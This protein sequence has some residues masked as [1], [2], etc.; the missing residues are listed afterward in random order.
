MAA[1]ASREWVCE[2]RRATPARPGAR[3]GG[4][5][6]E[7]LGK[8]GGVRRR[9]RFSMRGFFLSLFLLVRPRSR[10]AAR[11]PVAN[12]AGMGCVWVA[13]CPRE[14][15]LAGA[16]APNPD[17]ALTLR[18]AGQLLVPHLYSRLRLFSPPF[19]SLPTRPPFSIRLPG[20][21]ASGHARARVRTYV[22]T[23]TRMRE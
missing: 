8:R 18:Y 12:R 1:I 3:R 9:R 10:A 23:Y 2:T 19:V 7:G 11:L 14:A 15:R 4:C 5:A 17:V 16:V 22:H 21:R 6:W 20:H 13:P